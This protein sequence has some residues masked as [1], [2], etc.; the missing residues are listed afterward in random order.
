V[1]LMTELLSLKSVDRQRRFLD[2]ARKTLK[3]TGKLGVADLLRISPR[4]K[5]ALIIFSLEKSL[6]RHEQAPEFSPVTG[7]ARGSRV[8][9]TEP[10]PPGIPIL[11]VRGHGL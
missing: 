4:E 11:P 10:Y 5:L 7:I 2:L 9:E 6:A 8:P 1:V 3:P